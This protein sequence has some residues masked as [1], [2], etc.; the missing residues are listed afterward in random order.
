MA[1]ELHVVVITRID[2]ELGGRAGNVVTT[3]DNHRVLKGWRLVK[4]D[5]EDISHLRGEAVTHALGVARRRGKFKATFAGGKLTG[6]GGM[7]QIKAVSVAAVAAAKA[8][9]P[10]GDDDTARCEAAD[11]ACKHEE[12]MAAKAAAEASQDD[13]AAEEAAERA[14]SQADAEAAAAARA[15]ASAQSAAAAKEAAAAREVKEAAAAKEVA[16]ADQRQLAAWKATTVPTVGRPGVRALPE[17]ASVAEPQQALLS[18][19]STRHIK[20]PPPAKATLDMGPCDKCDGP[21]ATDACPH[22][23]KARDNHKDAWDGY[24][25]P[26]CSAAETEGSLAAQQLLR[27]ATVVAQPGDGSCLFHSLSYGTRALGGA[28]AELSTA[29]SARETVARFIEMHPD[30]ECAGSPLKD[31]IE[32]DSGMD[33]AAYCQRMRRPGEWG[34]AIELLVFSRL[35]RIPVLVYE[36]SGSPGAFNLISVVDI[37]SKGQPAER[38]VRVVYGGRC[39]YDALD[40]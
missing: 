7:L 4:I 1:D 25:Q 19:L 34:G 10:A 6:G 8:K 5:E 29:D 14:R 22:F 31:W 30:A 12:A 20:T 3:S 18:A 23:R 11:K 28:S 36:R 15:Q 17:R 35:A 2:F 37:D 38:A 27:G 26:V 33:P 16:A 9:K 13:K 40:L 32:W 39:H 24:N 21:H